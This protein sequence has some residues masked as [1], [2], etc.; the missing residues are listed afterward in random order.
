[1]WLEKNS[2]CTRI[3]E[4]CGWFLSKKALAQQGQIWFDLVIWDK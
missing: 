3:I 2:I 4:K 1:M